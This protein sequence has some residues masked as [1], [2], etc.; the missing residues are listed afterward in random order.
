MVTIIF[1]SKYIAEINTKKGGVKMAKFLKRMFSLI[2]I[3]TTVR[4]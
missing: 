2:G 1:I 4:W 3:G